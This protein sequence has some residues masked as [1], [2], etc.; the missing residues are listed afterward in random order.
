LGLKT[1]IITDLPEAMSA[2]DVPATR[3]MVIRLAMFEIENRRNER[4]L[5]GGAAPPKD[6]LEA[7]NV[8]L[9][10]LLAQAEI[11]AQELLAQ[12]GID[13]KERESADKLRSSRASV[14]VHL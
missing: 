14:V 8:S 6:L 2:F 7:E 1:A 4:R 10:L 11:D 12:A 9:R 5:D 3:L 13:A